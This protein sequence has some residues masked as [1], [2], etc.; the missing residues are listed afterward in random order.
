MKTL[1]LLAILLLSHSA[2]N[3]APLPVIARQSLVLNVPRGGKAAAAT[4]NASS[5]T[6]PASTAIIEGLKNTLASG[7]AAACSK[8]LLAP[9]DTIKTV[10]QDIKGGTSLKLMEAARKVMARPGGIFNLYVSSTL[11]LGRCIVRVH[12]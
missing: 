2:I 5:A 3:A 12:H 4:T 6:K 9:F 7:L 11:C 8:T 1:L 10:Q